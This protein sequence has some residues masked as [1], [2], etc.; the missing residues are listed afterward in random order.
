MNKLNLQ[1]AVLIVLV[2]LAISIYTGVFSKSLPLISL[3]CLVIL[4]FS[5]NSTKYATGGVI[6]SAMDESDCDN[7]GCSWLSST[8]KCYET[9]KT[10]DG[11]NAEVMEDDFYVEGT[12][13]A[14]D[15]Y[16]CATAYGNWSDEAKG[17]Q[18]GT[19][20]PKNCWLDTDTS[21]TGYKTNEDRLKAKCDS[22]GGVVKGKQ[23][24]K[25]STGCSIM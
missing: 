7:K 18:H 25:P 16:Q 2:I 3:I 11:S 19:G 5:Y 23:C 4:G 1:T 20:A 9:R 22:V 15:K 8:G 10:Q 6:D 12:Y 13:N 14:K 24:D 17:S 21:I